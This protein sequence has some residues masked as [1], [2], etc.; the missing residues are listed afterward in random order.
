MT[1]DESLAHLEQL[2]KESESVTKLSILVPFT[3]DR[4]I[5]FNNLY[6]EIYRQ[7]DQGGYLGKGIEKWEQETPRLNED[8]TPFLSE[9][10][11]PVVDVVTR[12]FKHPDTV[13]IVIDKKDLSIG[14]KR[15]SL[16]EKARGEYVCFVDSDD[17]ISSDYINVIMK[18][19]ESK[20]DCV[21]LRGVMTTDGERPELFEH[22][23]KYKEWKKTN[24]EIKYERYPNHLNTI[25]SSIAKQFKFPEKNFGEDFEYSKR[26][27][28]SG[29]LKVES[30]ID[31]V[32]YYYKFIEKK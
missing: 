28:E 11:T 8:L 16:L 15:N 19:I 26:I 18:A 7:I 23:L 1:L 22:S 13:E 4:G 17:W 29:L 10:G 24:N 21:S 12:Q 14:E 30:F 32:L 5:L 31:Q 2:K 3:G 9:F 6:Q 25:K 20:P 27:H